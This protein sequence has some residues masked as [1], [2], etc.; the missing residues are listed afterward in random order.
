LLVGSAVPIVVVR[1]SGFLGNL[2]RPPAR[3]VLELSELGVSWRMF[4]AAA[5]RG[6][7]AV[8]S[9]LL[10]CYFGLTVVA[11]LLELAL[12][13]AACWTASPG[14]AR[15]WKSSAEWCHPFACLE[16][17]LLAGVACVFELNTVIQF[18][19]GHSCESFEGIMNNKALLTIAGLGFAASDTCFAAPCRFGGGS[20]MAVGVLAARSVAWRFAEANAERRAR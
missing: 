20:L 9:I 18:N 4:R 5:D 14:R 3:Q 1:H 11:P 13:A 16:I 2:I 15:A 7:D 12:L 8:L 10:V 19:M 6:G 17:M